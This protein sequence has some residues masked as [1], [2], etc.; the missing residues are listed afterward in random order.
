MFDANFIPREAGSDSEKPADLTD[1]W[2]LPFHGHQTPLNLT[3]A[4]PG[5]CRPLRL[6]SAR[7]LARRVWLAG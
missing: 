4:R 3:F 1:S 6:T 2:D 5:L 7:T